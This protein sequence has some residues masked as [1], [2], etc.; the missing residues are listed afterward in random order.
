MAKAFGFS[1]SRNEILKELQHSNAFLA[2]SFIC[3]LYFLKM[4]MG[5]F[6][7]LANKTTNR[8][9]NFESSP[10]YFLLILILILMFLSLL[11]LSVKNISFPSSRSTLWVHLVWTIVLTSWFGYAFSHS[12]ASWSSTREEYLPCSDIATHDLIVVLIR[13]FFSFSFLSM[14][15][16]WDIWICCPRIRWHR[17]SYCQEWHI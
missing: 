5:R 9:R 7:F 8:E 13:L 14:S 11:L 6:L 15:G 4:F 10:Q 12:I 3:Y 17:P 2:T 16:G 1:R